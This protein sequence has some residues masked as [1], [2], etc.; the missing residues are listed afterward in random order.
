MKD[1]KGEKLLLKTKWIF[2]VK[3]LRIDNGLE[4]YNK[5]F[6][7][8]YEKNGIMRHKIVTYTPQQNSLTERMKRTLMEK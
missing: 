8:C 5:V 6:E 4:Y 1:L 7:E 2:N 3:T